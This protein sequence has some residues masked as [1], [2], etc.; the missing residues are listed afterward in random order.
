MK[1]GPLCQRPLLCRAERTV[2]GLSF[3]RRTSVAPALVSDWL[4]R[5]AVPL[6]P[7]VTTALP[8][9]STATEF[10]LA[11]LGQIMLYGQTRA[12]ALEYLATNPLLTNPLLLSAV[13]VWPPKS[14]VLAN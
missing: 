2:Y 11:L 12:P 1:K 6:K 9:E 5:V 10:A 8:K 13:K 14:N 7:P 4:P 3:I